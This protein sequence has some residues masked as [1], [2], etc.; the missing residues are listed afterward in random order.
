MIVA[1]LAIVGLF[2]MWR[3]NESI[4]W[5]RARR[6]ALEEMKSIALIQLNA[7]LNKLKGEVIQSYRWKLNEALVKMTHE[8]NIILESKF[9]EFNEVKKWG[10]D[11]A[12]YGSTHGLPKLKGQIQVIVELPTLAISVHP[13]KKYYEFYFKG[14]VLQ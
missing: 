14:G 1:I 10:A 7:E 9:D 4:K 6:S 13:G 3:L 8:F 5:D 11:V 2:F 12:H